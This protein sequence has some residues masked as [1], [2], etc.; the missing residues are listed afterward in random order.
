ME[1]EDYKEAERFVE[2]FKQIDFQVPFENLKKE[3]VSID[4]QKYYKDL[5]LIEK[6]LPTLTAGMM[7]LSRELEELMKNTDQIDPEV[8]SR[9]NPCL[10]LGQYLMR[11]NHNL[12]SPTSLSK[13][14][15]EYSQ[16]ENLNRFFIS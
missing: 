15:I 2:E 6:L 9:F 14:L 13:M 12:T 11:K 4:G 10:F 5:Y 16:I 3:V 1:S 7:E 8:R